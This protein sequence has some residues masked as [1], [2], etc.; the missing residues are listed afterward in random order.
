MGIVSGK[1]RYMDDLLALDS[2]RPAAPCLMWPKGP[3]P[4]ILPALMPFMWRHPDQQFASY[5]YN[6]L[7]HGFR[8]G[9]NMSSVLKPNW[10]NHPSSLDSPPVVESRIHEELSRGCLVGPLPPTQA[11]IVHVSP[12]GLVPK[13]HSNKF[14]M[15]VDLSS[16]RG[17]SV[18]VLNSVHAQSYIIPQTALSSIAQNSDIN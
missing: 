15:I 16:P 10:R 2:C 3:S 13:P 9:F 14:R 11:S 8:V 7:L 4:V 12:L 6:G 5:V 17:S 18:N 1:Y